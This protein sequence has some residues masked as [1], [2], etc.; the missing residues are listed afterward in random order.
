M[1]RLWLRIRGPWVRP[2]WVE[3]LYCG[4][5]E[6]A[7]WDAVERAEAA[8]PAAPVPAGVGFDRVV[9]PGRASTR[10]D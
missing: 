6:A 9:L 2:G 4:P 5:I 7:V 10:T 8:R 3:T 1:Y